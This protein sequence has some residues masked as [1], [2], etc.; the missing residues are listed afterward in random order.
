MLKVKHQLFKSKASKR[1][2]QEVNYR[3]QKKANERSKIIAKPALAPPTIL[4]AQASSMS[5]HYFGETLL[6][7]SWSRSRRSIQQ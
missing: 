4:T 1:K 5:R 3:S 2:Q 7:R 6:G